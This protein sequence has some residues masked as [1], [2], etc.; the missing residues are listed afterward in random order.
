LGHYN[1][2]ASNGASNPRIDARNQI[3][4]PFV[5]S[6]S[7]VVDDQHALMSHHS[8][9]YKDSVHFNDTGA[10]IQAAQVVAA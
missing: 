2:D 5:S 1:P 9:L 6:R 3:A 8:D 10:S 4:N 7:I